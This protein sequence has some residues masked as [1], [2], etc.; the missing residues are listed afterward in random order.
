MKKWLIFGGGFLTGIV[1]TILLLVVIGLAKQSSDGLIGATMFDEPGQA[2]ED[3]AFK[4]LQVID[5]NAALVNAKSGTYSYSGE[6]HFHGTLYVI[7]N[8]DGKYYYDE[9][10]I[11]VPSGK[12]ARH[13][14]IYKYTA[15][16]GDYKTVPVIKIMN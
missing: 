13:V 3:R 4:V 8:N 5:D 14:G 7:I 11:K 1:A 12:K 9:E 6:D 2:V 10:I 16:S 15:K